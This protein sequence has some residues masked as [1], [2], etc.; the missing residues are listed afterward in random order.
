M[1]RSQPWACAFV[2]F[3]AVVV[4][5]GG[6]TREE[7]VRATPDAISP[8][9]LPAASASNSEQTAS[10]QP[11]DLRA[12]DPSLIHSPSLD[13]AMLHSEALLALQAGDED[14]AFDLGRQAMRLAKDDPQ[15]VFLMA[16]ILGKRNRF[17]E[18]I[19]MVDELTET[20]PSLRLPAMGQ[21]A[22]WMVRYGQWSEAEKRYRAILDEV[23]DAVL[24]HR[25]LALLMLRQGRR[26]EAAQHL[27][28]L[29]AAGDVKEEEL[30]SLLMFV[31]P[32]AGDAI[33]GEFDPIGSL[34]KA[35]NEIG[36]ADLQAARERL[37]ALDSIGSEES[38]LLGRIYINL[39][40]FKAVEKW[41]A[42][43]PDSD[44]RH[45]DAWLAK[46]AYA[47]RQGDHAGA[48]RCFAEAVLRDQ[49][50]HQAYSLMS[51]SLNQL[52][53]PQEAA[54]A[55]HRAD[56]IKQTQSL[57][58][59]MASTEIREDKE[60]R[61]L[62]DLLD[63]LHRPLEALAWRGVQLAYAQT[64]ASV[65]DAEAQ[66]ALKRNRG[67]SIASTECEPGAGNSRVYTVRRRSEFVALMEISAVRSSFSRIL[68]NPATRLS[69]L[70]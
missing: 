45:A 27:G 64:M 26:M 61:E 62:I 50:D 5:F 24:V 66:Q 8:R 1:L 4:L 40:D 17:P 34:G 54:E 51:Q 2:C 41:I 67:R 49:T 53:A 3:C 58:A 63:Q 59:K 13:P 52:N 33:K 70:A 18:A 11:S 14:A 38:A 48:I 36:Q 23:P 56:L 37:E 44:E 9:P 68:A 46:G 29:C 22:E 42:T 16:M 6:C 65:S 35:R 60:M 57:G 19:E 32:F 43:R 39:K 21:T 55:L 69:S 10:P 47:A 31:H 30:R 12:S 15:V 20:N 7:S 28:F 25:N